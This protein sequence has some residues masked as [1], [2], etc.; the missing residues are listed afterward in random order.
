MFFLSAIFPDIFIVF[1]LLFSQIFLLFIFDLL[2]SQIFVVVHLLFSQMSLL[3]SILDLLFS[4]IFVVVVDSSAIF[5]VIHNK[6][7]S[8]TDLRVRIR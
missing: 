1:Y 2:F 8:T 6:T 5:P 4:Q 3:L 7:A